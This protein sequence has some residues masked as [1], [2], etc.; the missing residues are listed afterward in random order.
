MNT[1][2]LENSDLERSSKR[3]QG[4]R[5]ATKIELLCDS[6]SASRSLLLYSSFRRRSLGSRAGMKTTTILEGVVAQRNVF[7]VVI[8]SSGG[9]G[10]IFD[11]ENMLYSLAKW[12]L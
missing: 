5:A 3:F 12:G 9:E 6:E 8:A 11:R 7:L 10:S 1:L 4:S 2:Q